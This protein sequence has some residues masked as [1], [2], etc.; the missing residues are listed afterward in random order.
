MSM[1]VSIEDR[2]VRKVAI[3]RAGMAALV[4][5][6]LLGACK[7]AEVV[8]NSLPEDG[9]RTRYP[10]VLADT[11]KTL[12]IPV[13]YGSAGLSPSSRANVRAFAAEASETGTGSLVILTP[14]GSANETAAAYVAR[15]ARAEAKAGGLA[16]SLIETRP[17]RVDDPAAVAP[18]RLS[19]TRIAAVSPPCGRWRGQILPSTH[20]DDGDEFGCTTQA[21]LAAMV[22]NPNDLITP[23]AGTAAPAQRRWVVQDKY[24]KGEPPSGEY[25]QTEYSQTSGE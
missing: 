16:S 6:L 3:G 24:V 12:D 10:I 25:E 22:E 2:P 11:P 15:Q 7:S 14:S 17:Y 13:G 20:M 1:N 18:I 19:Y 8:T 4:A 5:A 21:N 9:Y 23:R